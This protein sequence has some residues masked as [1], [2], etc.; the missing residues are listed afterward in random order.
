MNAGRPVIVQQLPEKLSREQVPPFL[1]DIEPFLQGERPRIVFDFSQVAQVD[2]AGIEMLLSCMEEVLKRNGD[3]KLA[4]VP[5]EAAVVLE[6]TGVD[7][8]FEIFDDPADAA[9][10]FHRFPAHAFQQTSLSGNLGGVSQTQEY[11]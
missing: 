7:R 1:Q 4:A 2:S 6:L 5:P 8:L 11:A 3:L 9:E 10:S